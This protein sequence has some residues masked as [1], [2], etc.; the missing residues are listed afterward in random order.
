MANCGNCG[1]NKQICS[2]YFAGDGSTTTVVGN[3]LLTSPVAFNKIE[4]PTPRPVADIARSNSSGSLNIPASTF[5]LIPFDLNQMV[6]SGVNFGDASMVAVPNRITFTTAGKYFIGGYLLMQ[7]LT[8]VAANSNVHVF[9]SQGIPAGANVYVAE[10]QLRAAQNPN[11]VVQALSPFS[12]V[13]V[14]AGQYMEMYVFSSIVDIVPS[15]ATAGEGTA[16]MYA[17]WMDE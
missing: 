3:G 15:G 13:S 14:T 4:G 10:S 7:E 11:G 5:T 12:F 17:I 1:S 16:A 9:L 6:R 8:A 2:C